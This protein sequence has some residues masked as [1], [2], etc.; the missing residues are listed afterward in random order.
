M[1]EPQHDCSIHSMCPPRIA[2]PTHPLVPRPSLT[3]AVA[4]PTRG[5]GRKWDATEITKTKHLA[6]AILSSHGRS[7]EEFLIIAKRPPE[8]EIYPSL[9]PRAQTRLTRVVWLKNRLVL[10]RNRVSTVHVPRACSC[11]RPYASFCVRPRRCNPH[12]RLRPCRAR[13]MNPA[14]RASDL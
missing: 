9:V 12:R 10:R 3:W 6:H 13:P 1:T 7:F 11:A 4:T 14:G 5:G 2:A 8:F